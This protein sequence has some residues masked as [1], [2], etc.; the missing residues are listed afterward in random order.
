MAKERL[1]SLIM[2]TGVLETFIEESSLPI[3]EGIKVAV[4]NV[5][6]KVS[7]AASDATNANDAVC[8]A[9]EA[10]NLA[11]DAQIGAQIAVEKA[12][13]A[14]AKAEALA[15]A[16]AEIPVKIRKVGT[17]IAQIIG[18]I[19]VANPNAEIY[20]MGYYNA[21]PYLSQEV[22][23]GLTLGLI[24]N[25]NNTIEMATKGSGATFIPTFQLFEGNYQTYLPNPRN[26]HPSDAGYGG[27]R[28]L[29]DSW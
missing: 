14:V 3:P 2:N 20:V 27:K 25:L 15:K 1:H 11:I 17:N 10:V 9:K 28:L 8:N 24:N 22:Q 19:K 7:Q 23:Q 18:G 26:I 29:L 12:E 5:K 6:E 16:V 21:L 13:I 4:L